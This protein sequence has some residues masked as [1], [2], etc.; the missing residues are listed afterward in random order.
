MPFDSSPRSFARLICTLPGSTAP[1][2]ATATL[3]PRR[4]FGA[5]QMICSRSLARPPPSMVTSHTDNL[6][7]SGCRAHSSTSP[8]TTPENGGATGWIDSTSRPASVRREASSAGVAASGV[9]SFIH[10]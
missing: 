10:E 4:T 3:S 2:V 5:P 8:T 6:S 9:N 1:T 7:A